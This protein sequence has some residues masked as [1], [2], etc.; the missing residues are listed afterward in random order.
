MKKKIF[1]I[2]FVTAIAI[3]AAWNFSQNKAEVELSDLALENVEA[4]AAGEEGISSLYRKYFCAN[5][6]YYKCAY[7]TGESC[8]APN[9][10]YPC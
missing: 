1:S 4:L 9:P 6:T 8:P 10:P 2:V 3:A 5:T 7:G